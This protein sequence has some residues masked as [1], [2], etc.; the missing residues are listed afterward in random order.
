MK[1]SVIMLVCAGVLLLLL[2]FVHAEEAPVNPAAGLW[3]FIRTDN[4]SNLHFSSYVELRP[5]GTYIFQLV[6]E[7]YVSL[8]IESCIAEDDGFV[9]EGG[10]YRSRFTAEG[11]I[12]TRTDID[13][14][15]HENE[16][17]PDRFRR[18]TERP[19]E[20]FRVLR[21]GDYCYTL[22]GSGNAAIARYIRK[23]AQEED[24]LVLPDDLDGHRVTSVMAG[25]FE[26]ITADSA[27]LPASMTVIGDAAFSRSRFEYITIPEG[28]TEIDPYAFSESAVSGIT[29]P[30]SL[31]VIGPYAFSSCSLLGEITLPE[32]LVRIGEYAFERCDS[33]EQLDLPET[34]AVLE[35]NPFCSCEALTEIRISAD[36][37]AFCVVDGVLFAREDHRLIWY[38]ESS[39]RAQYIVPKDTVIIGDGA[40]AGNG[41][42]KAVELPEALKEIGKDAFRGCSLL[43][44]ITIPGSVERIGAYAFAGCSLKEISIPEGITELGNGLF[45]DNAGLRKVRLPDSLTRIGDRAFHGCASLSEIRIPDHV[46]SIGWAAFYDCISLTGVTLPEGLQSIGHQAFNGCSKLTGIRIPASVTQIGHLAFS[47]YDRSLNREV[48]NPKLTMTVAPGSYAEQFCRENGFRFKTKK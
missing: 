29:L 12:L 10:Y 38:P 42:L 22:D 33:L 45:S 47:V 30:S 28:V 6:D 2:S 19:P 25:A 20:L 14:Y 1:R 24:V 46:T 44:D 37:P 8:R 5:D 32:G 9:L 4:N 36:H 17:G 26:G 18:I 16:L 21:S 34:L 43:A 48:P 7:G 27:V 13:P 40:F 35:G 39:T 3:E 11:D 15:G 41:H 31:R 23:A